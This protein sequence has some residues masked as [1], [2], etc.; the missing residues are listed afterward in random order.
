M[1]SK[2]AGTENE[3]V[4]CF[5][6]KWKFNTSNSPLKLITLATKVLWNEDLNFLKDSKFKIKIQPNLEYPE[7]LC[8]WKKCFFSIQSKFFLSNQHLNSF[9]I[10]FYIYSWKKY[11]PFSQEFSFRKGKGKKMRRKS[12]NWK[13]I[14][15]HKLAIETRKTKG[16]DF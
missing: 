6:N 8:P 2:I 16:K 9:A 11:F 7:M 14:L 4:Y 13:E 1:R 5:K 12:Q 3:Q 15:P 10:S